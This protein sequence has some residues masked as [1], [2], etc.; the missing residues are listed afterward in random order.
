[1]PWKRKRE[2][3][4]EKRKML[5]EILDGTEQNVCFACVQINIKKGISVATDSICTKDALMY[6]HSCQ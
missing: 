5:V 3:G 2:E 1:M 6:L 4:E